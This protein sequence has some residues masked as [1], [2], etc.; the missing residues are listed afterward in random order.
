MYAP[1]LDKD[2]RLT[3][4]LSIFFGVSFREDTSSSQALTN[5]FQWADFQ[6]DDR[7]GGCGYFW[8]VTGTNGSIH[9]NFGLADCYAPRPFVCMAD[10][11]R[12]HKTL[13]NYRQHLNSPEAFQ[14][15][16]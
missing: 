5:G 14:S 9:L 8:P 1:L 15:I 13:R 4:F 16:L 3:Q 12:L 2:A 10:Q 6:P 7:S 11:I